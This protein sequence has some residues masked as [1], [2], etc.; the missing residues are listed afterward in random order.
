[1]SL[2][3]TTCSIATLIKAIGIASL[4]PSHRITANQMR[5]HPRALGFFI[6]ARFPSGPT[7]LRLNKS[8]SEPVEKT[9][10][11]KQELMSLGVLENLS[12]A[13]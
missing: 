5:A 9:T 12:A 7:E 11:S 8:G 4:H 3:N 1:M 10:P 2:L 6:P 13:V